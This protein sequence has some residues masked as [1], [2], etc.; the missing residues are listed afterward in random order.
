MFKVKVIGKGKDRGKLL[1]I[2]IAV[3]Y[4]YIEGGVEIQP[5]GM[6]TSFPYMYDKYRIEIMEV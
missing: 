6:N 4:K 3:N 2:F 1:D 5:R